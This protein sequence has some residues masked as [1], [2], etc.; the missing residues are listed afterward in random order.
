L[1]NAGAR[2]ALTNLGLHDL[3]RVA[4]DARAQT[5]EFI[6]QA[7]LQVI[8]IDEPDAPALRDDSL[9]PELDSWRTQTEFRDAVRGTN[10]VMILPG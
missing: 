4:K 7:E 9:L 2:L 1:V 6:E 10:G 5:R 8:V 3:A